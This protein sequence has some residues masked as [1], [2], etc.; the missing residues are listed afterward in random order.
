MNVAAMPSAFDTVF[1]AAASFAPYLAYAFGVWM[2]GQLKLYPRLRNYEMYL[3]AI[4]VGLIAVSGLLVSTTVTV[5][6]GNACQCAAGT[7]ETVYGHFESLPNGLLFLGT[8]MIFGTLVPDLFQ[9][10]RARTSAS[11]Q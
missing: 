1:M 10:I 6:P 11:T 5:L 8:M 4:P 9:T 7:P 2:A 3:M